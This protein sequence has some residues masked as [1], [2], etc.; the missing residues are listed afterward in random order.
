MP[1]VSL[2]LYWMR[3]HTHTNTQTAV[4]RCF[5]YNSYSGFSLVQDEA[6]FWVTRCSLISKRTAV[7]EKVQKINPAS[8]DVE[9]RSN[10]TYSL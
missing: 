3:A 1:T 8:F 2:K 6:V 10:G 4:C 7:S 5:T 9:P